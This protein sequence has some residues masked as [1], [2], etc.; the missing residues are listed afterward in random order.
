MSGWYLLD[1]RWLLALGALALPVILHLISQG[2]TRRV[3]VGSVGLLRSGKRRR[4]RRIRPTQ[5]LLLALRCMLLIALAL[6][7]AGLMFDRL[8]PGSDRVWGLMSASVA[9]ERAAG[10]LDDDVATRLEVLRN[11]GSLRRLQPGLPVVTSWSEPTEDGVG[12][13][14][15][16]GHAE[17][18]WSYLREAAVVAPH[19]TRFEI[20]AHDRVAHLAGARPTLSAPVTW[21]SI[22]PIRTPG[23]AQKNLP[24][25]ST[26]GATEPSTLV[27]ASLKVM[28]RHSSD[29]A[30]DAAYMTAAVRSVAGIPPWTTDG[31]STLEL[32]VEAGEPEGLDADGDGNANVLIWL[33]DEPLPARWETAVRAGAILLK[34]RGGPWSECATSVAVND[35]RG[36]GYRP[37]LVFLR[38]RCM[39]SDV[40]VAAAEDL[41]TDHAVWRDARGQTVL[42][43]A[44]RDAGL[45]WTLAGRFH[46]DWSS[47]VLSAAFPRWLSRWLADAAQWHGHVLPGIETHDLR[48]A[49]PQRSPRQVARADADDQSPAAGG[50]RVPRGSDS[51]PSPWWGLVAG[52][53]AVERFVALRRGSIAR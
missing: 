25:F 9:A 24:V 33:A 36:N 14:A 18:V 31:R 39:A 40:V 19:D 42:S 5:L 49:G 51:T 43:R 6:A 47:L 16:P 29:R 48:P 2:T 35:G 34:D 41:A 11:A 20:F 23:R 30:E 21:H 53:V 17:D 38:A 1:P 52:L 26:K 13:L 32:A 7:L 37:P 15:S 44:R 3:K 46:P 27:P 12:V 28:V 45:A 4:A 8:A 10:R 50:S 22:D